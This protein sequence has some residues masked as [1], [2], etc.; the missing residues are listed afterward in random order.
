MRFLLDSCRQLP[1]NHVKQ[2][3][4]RCELGLVRNTDGSY[5]AHGKLGHDA[6]VVV[7]SMSMCQ[8]P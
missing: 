6:E 7:D 3:W 5:V 2:L 1:D 8:I 4:M